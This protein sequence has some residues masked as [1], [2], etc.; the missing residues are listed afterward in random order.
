VGAFEGLAMFAVTHELCARH[1]E[2]ATRRNGGTVGF[3][4]RCPG[5]GATHGE[6]LALDDIR[7]HVL[8]LARQGGFTGTLEELSEAQYDRLLLSPSLIQSFLALGD[9]LRQFERPQ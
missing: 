2:V 9:R 4:V 8:R 7:G 6:A 3:T 5:C 1:I